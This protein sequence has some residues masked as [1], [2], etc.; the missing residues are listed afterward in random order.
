VQ[1]T[2]KIFLTIVVGSLRRG[3]AEIQLNEILPGLDKEKYH[4][5]VVLISTRGE[6]ADSLEKNGV[7]IINPWF[8]TKAKP[9]NILSRLFRFFIIIPQLFIY[10]ITNRPDIVHFYLPQSYCLVMPIVIITGI[11]NIVMS[12]LS[13]NNYKD[14]R[15]WMWQFEKVLHFFVKKVVVNS[16]FIKKQM[17]KDEAV[18]QEKVMRI[19]SGIKLDGFDLDRKQELREKLGLS[20]EQLILVMVAN[21][22]PYKGH[23][24]LISALGLIS[25]EM[26]KD[27]K[28]IFIGRDDGIKTALIDQTKKYNISENCEFLHPKGDITDYYAIADIGILSSHE[29]GFSI[30]IL[31]GMRAA[32]PM[33]V[34][35]VG[36]NSESVLDGKTGFVVPAQ[37]CQKISEAILKLCLDKEL[38]QS[39][40]QSANQRVKD[41]FSIESCI[42]EHHVLYSNLI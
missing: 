32:L 24:D 28:M 14:S 40:G 20:S 23:A 39:M 33:V 31:E 18:N 7:K 8:D 1:R 12:R 35:N 36:G 11:H 15:K 3:G 38:R 30:A 9:L 19:Y 26:P 34:T 16:E 27:W 4:I 41:N 42:N 2:K 21:L 5:E 25:D 17:I 13:L 22:I 6:L 29:E 10:F 37:D